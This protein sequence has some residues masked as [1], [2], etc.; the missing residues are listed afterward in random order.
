MMQDERPITDI[1]LHV[2]GEMS[3]KHRNP[4]R[5]RTCSNLHIDGL[6]D[7]RKHEHTRVM[8][9]HCLGSETALMLAHVLVH[10]QTTDLALLASQT[11]HLTEC[12]QQIVRRLVMIH[13]EHR[14]L[15]IADRLVEK[16]PLGY[17]SPVR[18]HDALQQHVEVLKL[19]MRCGLFERAPAVADIC[20]IDSDDLLVGDNV[21]DLIH[22]GIVVDIHGQRQG[23]RNDR[24][25]AEVAPGFL[26]AEARVTGTSGA[27]LAPNLQH[28]GVRPASR[29]R[30][31]GY[32][33]YT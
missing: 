5:K 6:R 7:R 24:P 32:S 14:D 11:W 21:P 33:P 8:R 19:H 15:S 30:G 13:E 9:R 18:D 22:D 25:G 1:F 26:V 12:E 20:L 3:A 2:F 29:P 27:M 10:V 16:L 28:V 31:R 17:S 4:S 23:R